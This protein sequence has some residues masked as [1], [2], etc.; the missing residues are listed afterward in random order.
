MTKYI[1]L[2][3]CTSFLLLVGVSVLGSGMESTCNEKRE[4][5]LGVGEEIRQA[6]AHVQVSKIRIFNRV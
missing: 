3:S 4:G 6:K 5:E 1:S 2:S